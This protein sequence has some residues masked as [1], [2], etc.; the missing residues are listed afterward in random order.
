MK[1]ISN[2]VQ[3][4]K[5]LA[6]GLEIKGDRRNVIVTEILEVLDMISQAMED[7][8][9]IVE[10]QT[11]HIYTLMNG[12]SFDKENYD[13]PMINNQTKKTVGANADV[14]YDDSVVDKKASKTPLYKKTDKNIPDKIKVEKICRH[15]GT[16]I[17]A[18]YNSDESDRVRLQCPKCKHFLMPGI[19]NSLGIEDS[20]KETTLQD[21]LSNIDNENESPKNIDDLTHDFTWTGSDLKLE[22]ENSSEKNIDNSDLEISFDTCTSAVHVEDDKELFDA[23]LNF[24]SKEKNNYFEE[25]V[26]NGFETA[27]SNTSFVKDN[28]Y[29]TYEIS[30]GFEADFSEN[31]F[32]S[33]EDSTT[34]PAKEESL[35][36][37]DAINVITNNKGFDSE[38]IY[39]IE[40]SS[41]SESDEID[42]NA[43]ED[44]S[45]L[46]EES[47]SNIYDI[48]EES[49]DI[50][51][52][53]LDD[54]VS[55]EQLPET[56]FKA[57]ETLTKDNYPE[58]QKNEKREK[59]LNFLKSISDD[60]SDDELFLNK[61]SDKT[62]ESVEENKQDLK[63]NSSTSNSK[64]DDWNTQNLGDSWVIRKSETLNKNKYRDE[65]AKKST[66]FIKKDSTRP[67]IDKINIENLLLF[68][69]SKNKTVNKK[70]DNVVDNDFDNPLEN[71][72]DNP[73]ENDLNDTILKNHLREELSTDLE[74]DLENKKI[75]ENSS[76]NL[77]FDKT[78][79]DEDHPLKNV[80][81]NPLKNNGNSSQDGEKKNIEKNEE[82]GIFKRQN[83]SQ[84]N[85]S[86]ES[87][88]S[89]N[90]VK[91]FDFLEYSKRLFNLGK[92]D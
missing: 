56:E 37:D 46:E 10:E 35:S 92:N 5:G 90:T 63:L 64:N 12:E 22:T 76:E 39:L 77:N 13:F 40:E 59:A 79:N 45:F 68:K 70:I 49:D 66:N 15:C 25:E 19:K 65:Y 42:L 11:E 27:S 4:I 36:N 44:P 9:A 16:Y 43:V 28:S 17:V 62:E 34:F 86:S 73:L 88:V 18:E 54:L 81:K 26:E 51:E 91:N 47:Y 67:S 78:D 3:Y 83:N 41:L 24:N 1:K 50:A 74:N 87:K 20:E 80:F 23:D 72:F 61:P 69:D 14:W 60:E 57:T 7:M 6:D 21:L 2:K 29:H 71:D 84:V 55:E 89:A 32:I 38:N 8:E 58:N 30:S 31:S 75:S 85:N 53:K 82:F 33:D 52:E 48:E